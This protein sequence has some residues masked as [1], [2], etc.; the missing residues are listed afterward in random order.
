M[1]SKLDYN[2]ARHSGKPVV[3]SGCAAKDAKKKRR[4]RKARYIAERHA[5]QRIAAEMPVEA[6]WASADRPWELIKRG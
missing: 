1:S 4:A 6:S 2:K 5:R 3:G